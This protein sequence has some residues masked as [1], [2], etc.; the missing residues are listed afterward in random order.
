[1]G[2]WLVACALARPQVAAPE[3]E[4]KAAFLTKF[5]QFVEWPPAAWDGRSTLDVCVLR[6]H[7]FGDAL[8]RLGDGETVFGRPLRIR[9]VAR[10]HPLASCHVLFVPSSSEA[11]TRDVLRAVAGH[12]VLTV[13]D[14]PGFLEAGGIINLGVV[15]GKVR[16]EINAQVAADAGLRL[17]SQLLRLAQHVRGAR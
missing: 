15:D 12:P 3:Y 17:S 11:A 14:R 1:V 5:P 16:F 2:V 7:P 8:G 6:P 4:V 10:A 13:G 9:Q